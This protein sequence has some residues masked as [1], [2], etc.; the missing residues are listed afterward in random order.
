MADKMP[1]TTIESSSDDAP[2]A[3]SEPMLSV[4]AANGSHDEQ[5]KD[6]SSARSTYAHFVHMLSAWLKRSFPGH[7]HAF[8]G[9]VIGLV[10]AVL[11]FIVGIAKTLAITVFVVAGIAVGQLLD[12]DPKIINALRAL[13]ESRNA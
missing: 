1:R 2:K 3:S 8:L 7:E 9:G 11:I 4:S 10:I 6:S 12:G 5:A 13:F